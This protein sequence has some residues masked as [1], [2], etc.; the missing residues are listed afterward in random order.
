MASCL[1]VSR[2][3]PT[4]DGGVGWA[5]D[6]GVAGGIGFGID[7]GTGGATASTGT[8]LAVSA[9]WCDPSADG[10]FAAERLASGFTEF[11]RQADMPISL[12]QALD[13]SVDEELLG[14]LSLEATQQWTGTFN[15]RKMDEA[16]FNAIYRRAL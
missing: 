4:G 5:I 6:S 16:S 11:L 10:M 2:F 1:I 3:G 9:G 14:R 7:V 12:A 13:T 8:G 15:P